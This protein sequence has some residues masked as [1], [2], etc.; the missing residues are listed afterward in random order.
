MKTI[1]I[2]E[3]E[4]QIQCNAFTR[5]N[6]KKI[7]NAGIFEDIQRIN[8]FNIEQEEKRI[9]LEKEGKSKEQIDKEINNLMLGRLDDILD[10]IQKIA[11]IE[12]YTA[13]NK[14]GSF[15]EWLGSIEKIN[16][17]EPW[18]AEVTEYAVNSFLG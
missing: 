5:F 15:E 12:I 4:Y 8:T 6:Y 2:N 3:K 9:A 11:Y 14:I 1:T 7:F 10:A 17:S 18:I 13:N 16:L